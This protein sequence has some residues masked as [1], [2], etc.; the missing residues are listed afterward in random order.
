MPKFLNVLQNFLVEIIVL[1]VISLKVIL[2]INK[3]IT[4]NSFTYLLTKILNK[5]LI[6][7]RSK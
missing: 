7:N 1:K 5:K 3:N 6:E 4:N 2:V